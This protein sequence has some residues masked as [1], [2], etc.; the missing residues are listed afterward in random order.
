MLHYFGVIYK[1]TN[2]QNNKCYIGKTI[3]FISRKNAQILELNQ[4]KKYYNSYFQNSWNK[5]KEYNFKWEI[6]GECFSKEELNIAE[7][8]CILFFNST[9]PT[10]GYNVAKGG[11]GGNTCSGIPKSLE[12]RKKISITI[13]EKGSSRGEKNPGYNTCAYNR[14]LVK[15]GKEV[16]DEKHLQRILKLKQT[17]QS[18]SEEEKRLLSKKLHD[19]NVGKN[20][21]MYGKSVYDV[22]AMKYGKEVADEKKKRSIEKYKISRNNMNNQEMNSKM[23]IT[24]AKKSQEEKQQRIHKIIETYKNKSE[25]EKQELINKRV[26][27]YK[28]K[29]EEEKQQIKLKRKTTRERNKLI[30]EVL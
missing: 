11:E 17:L 23:K 20:N 21:A 26:Q 9:N 16:A 6:L 27:T 13:K 30:G 2:I 15:F 22:W 29:T 28:N 10:Y 14:W 18:R 4:N 8:E 19:C 3:N 25:E 24:N 5:Y 12:H 1:V 7:K